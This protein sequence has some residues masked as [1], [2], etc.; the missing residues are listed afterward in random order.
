[1]VVYDDDDDDEVITPKRKEILSIAAPPEPVKSPSIIPDTETAKPVQ[2]T[3]SEILHLKELG[4]LVVAPVVVGAVV[5]HMRHRR[6]AAVEAAEALQQVGG[7]IAEQFSPHRDVYTRREDLL[8][9][10][11]TAADAAD[12]PADIVTQN[13]GSTIMRWVGGK[14][15]PTVIG[16]AATAVQLAAAN[17][18]VDSGAFQAGL[19][20]VS[21]GTAKVAEVAKEMIDHV[22]EVGPDR[23]QSLSERFKLEASALGSIISDAAAATSEAVSDY[24]KPLTIEEQRARDQQEKEEESIRLGKEAVEIGTAERGFTATK[25]SAAPLAYES[26]FVRSNATIEQENATT[27]DEYLYVEEEEDEEEGL[28]VT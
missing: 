22:V 4:I 6:P 7:R 10:V 21:A 1:L 15:L 8:P 5:R 17:Y 9:D 23:L 2:D 3:Y 13:P 11:L 27:A 19:D 28:T 26:E 12:I 24:M 20:K 18:L 16:P 14:L 25:H